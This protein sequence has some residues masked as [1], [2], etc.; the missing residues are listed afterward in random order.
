MAEKPDDL[1]AVRRLTE[2]LS[3]FDA[4]DQE[5]IIRWTR[6]K[7][8]LPTEIVGPARSERT[9][10]PAATSQQE[11]AGATKDIKTFVTGK[12]PSSDNQFT[13]T[14]A[15]YYRF[16]APQAARKEFI[17]ADDLQQA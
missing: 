10:E 16:M 3:P 1:K 15:Y 5:R 6:E 8:G 2:A 4:G 12:N 11:G 14:V 9:S 17:T 7:L 13:T